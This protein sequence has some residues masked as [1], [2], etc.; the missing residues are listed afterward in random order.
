MK[1]MKRMF[2]REK[3][4]RRME[5]LSLILGHSFLIPSRWKHYA[6]FKYEVRVFSFLNDQFS[7]RDVGGKYLK[8]TTF[9]LCGKILWERRDQAKAGRNQLKDLG[10]VGE[11]VEKDTLKNGKHCDGR[12]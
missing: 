8:T 12:Y 11:L 6:Q 5:A 3:R 1:R 7:L 10:D 4:N 9:Y 2:M